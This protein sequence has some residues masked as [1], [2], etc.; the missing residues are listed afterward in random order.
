MFTLVLIFNLNWD[1]ILYLAGKRTEQFLSELLIRQV[2]TTYKTTEESMWQP[3]NP[4]IC[5]LTEFKTNS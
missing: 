2:M 1:F 5:E 4:E 3:G